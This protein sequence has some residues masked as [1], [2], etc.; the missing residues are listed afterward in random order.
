[1]LGHI[2][3]DS[4]F[5]S[6]LQRKHPHLRG[7]ALLA[8]G[9]GGGCVI[10][11]S[12]EA[13]ATGVKTGMP[14]KEARQ[15]CP[16][17]VEMPCD[18]R[19]TS[20]ASKQLENLLGDVCPVIEQFS[21]D[22][23]FFD[24]RT[25][26]GGEPKD[27]YAWGIDLQRIMWSKTGLSVSI[28]IGPNK[29]LAK[30]G[31]EYKK[32]SGVSVVVPD[33]QPIDRA[34]R[35]FGIEE[36]LRDRPAP[37]IPG[38][39]RK[40]TVHTEQHGWKTAWDIAIAPTPQLIKLFGRPGADLQRELKGELLYKITTEDIDPKSV[41]RCRSFRATTDRKYAWAHVLHHAEYVVN[42]MRKRQLACRGISVWLRDSTYRSGRSA[43]CSLPQAMDTE[44][45]LLPFI[46]NAFDEAWQEGFRCTQAG[47]G[48]WRLEPSHT[49][50]YSLFEET[51]VRDEDEE[52][53][54]HLD[55]IRLKYGRDAVVRGSALPVSEGTKPAVNF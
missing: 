52:L 35:T 23:W 24:L 25:I 30:M 55:E 39:G 7:K 34:R 40:R 38:I 16:G 41:S 4:F 43:N 20:I 9:M 21:I 3:A 29:L 5:A 47:L 10:A 17:A 53:Q 36:F 45:L 12:Y 49:A 48:L 42:R 37:A 54:E 14:L 51:S 15:L 22:E 33:G 8:L 11:A 31:S 50:Q 18:Y 46:R 32:P 1:M 2:D 26:Q 13:K 28:G 6:V 44:E 27:L 19:E